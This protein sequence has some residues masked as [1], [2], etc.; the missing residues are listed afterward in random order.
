MPRVEANTDHDE[1]YRA[2]GDRLSPHG[3]R[4]LGGFH[5]DVDTPI[6]RADGAL[7]ATVVL[8]G[9]AGAAMWWPFSSSLEFSAGAN[10]LE[11][12]ISRVVGEIAAALGAEAVY[13]SDGPPYHP[14]QQ[15]AKRTGAAFSSPIGMLIRA[16]VGLWHAYRAALLFPQRLDLPTV[17]DE[18][19]PCDGCAHT[20]CL[21]T[22]PVSAFGSDGY[23][24]GA[25]AA[26][27]HD[28]AGADCV[29]LGCRA[30][31]AC[32]V[33]RDWIYPPA[34]AAFH[35]AAFVAAHPKPGR[36]ADGPSG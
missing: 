30:R 33:G 1:A 21:T 16:D 8:I 9:N 27:L 29:G 22:C 18:P 15:W 19:S 6:V 2:L 31:R 4:V 23:D 26:H 12:W 36:A 34:L 14:F 3:L 24:V 11:R 5:P 20:P 13:P 17:S 25:C 10:P 35:Q 7:A 28:P 32:P